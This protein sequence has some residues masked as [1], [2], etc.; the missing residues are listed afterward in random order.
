ML[1]NARWVRLMAA[2]SL[3]KAMMSDPTTTPGWK[4]YWSGGPGIPGTDSYT[5]HDTRDQALRA[6]CDHFPLY[7]DTGE[8]LR[9]EGPNGERISAEEIK[10]HCQRNP[11]T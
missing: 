9:V 10:A 2:I 8:P 1:T 3:R 11:R 4:V 5:T 7:R 6:A